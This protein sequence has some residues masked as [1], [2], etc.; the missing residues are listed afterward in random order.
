MCIKYHE[1]ST[2][3]EF[4]LKCIFNPIHAWNIIKY[5]LQMLVKA[6]PF[7]QFCQFCLKLNLK[8]SNQCLSSQ[9]LKLKTLPILTSM[10]AHLKRWNLKHGHLRILV[11]IHIGALSRIMAVLADFQNQEWRSKLRIEKI[12]CGIKNGM[13]GLQCLDC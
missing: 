6:A 3:N 7:T 8:A 10:Q 4:E 2:S 11:H 12:F 9:A 13:Y 5:Q 1:I